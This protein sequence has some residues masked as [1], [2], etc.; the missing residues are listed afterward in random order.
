MTLQ[1]TVSGRS[2]FR[3]A[4]LWK[5]FLCSTLTLKSAGIWRVNQSFLKKKN[6]DGV[7]EEIDLAQTGVIATR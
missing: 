2:S 6:C 3:K 7:G 1:N 5:R 4:E